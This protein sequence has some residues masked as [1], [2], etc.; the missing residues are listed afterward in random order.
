MKHLRHIYV[1]LL[2]AVLTACDLEKE[3]DVSLP[4]HTP[5]LVVEC[6]LEP[7]E[8]LRAIVLESSGYFEEPTPPL[9][10]DAVVHIT[11]PSGKRVK[12]AY[13]PVLVK[14]T[15]RFYTHTSTEIMAGKPGEIYQLE[16]EDGKG[17]R[18]TGFTKIQP[19]VPI[20]EVTWKFNDKDEAYLLTTFQDDPNTDNYYRYMTHID[21]R[22]GSSNRDFV[23]SDE[24][25]NR[26]RTFLCAAYKYE[27]GRSL[28][29][30]LFHIE[31]QYYGCL[32]SIS[33]AKNANGN[34]FAQPSRIKSSVEGGI[35]VFTN[36]AYD[37]K[38][39]VITR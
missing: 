27:D 26:K 34:P 2:V 8:P 13:M 30:T 6:Y 31:K 11:T 16:V 20:E 7:G 18:I 28:I 4:Q 1:L 22:D 25:T 36:L 29:V 14:S 23:I 37:R 19:K 21:I 3:I 38:T 15:G 33:D 17:R 9:V 10:P 39:V 5:Q 32:A 35:G 12:L 24:L